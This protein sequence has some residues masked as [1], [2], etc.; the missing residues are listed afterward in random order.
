MVQLLA[1][2]L[3]N[4][5]RLYFLFVVLHLCHAHSTVECLARRMN[6]MHSHRDGSLET[7]KNTSMS[8][9]LKTS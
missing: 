9:C 3:L 6:G 5:G 7:V 8:V 4:F 1:Y 2:Q